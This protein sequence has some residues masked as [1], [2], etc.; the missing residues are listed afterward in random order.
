VSL[1][2]QDREDD[3]G[4]WYNNWHHI[5]GSRVGVASRSRKG[6]GEMDPNLPIRYNG[7][8][9]IYSPQGS[10]G[11]ERNDLDHLERCKEK[12]KESH[13][14]FISGTAYCTRKV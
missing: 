14:I 10:F 3:I 1:T 11:S 7:L 6:H 13:V 5:I 12:C 8:M 4:N 2:Y 9:N